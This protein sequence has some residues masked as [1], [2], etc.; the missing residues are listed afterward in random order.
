L[1]RSLS[2]NNSETSFA[3]NQLISIFSDLK[4][5]QFSFKLSFWVEGN[6]MEVTMSIE[7]AL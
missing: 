5:A 3:Q 4:E 6:W 2:H 7:A 1:E